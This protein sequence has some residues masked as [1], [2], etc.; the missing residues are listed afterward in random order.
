MLHI[1]PVTLV[2]V[3]EHFQDGGS[4]HDRQRWEAG[5][6]EECG[7]KVKV[8]Y[9][10]RESARRHVYIASY[11]LSLLVVLA[12]VRLWFLLSRQIMM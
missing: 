2:C 9:D 10:V 6:V 11:A 5:D 3:V 1:L 8:E 4:V 12:Y 7:G